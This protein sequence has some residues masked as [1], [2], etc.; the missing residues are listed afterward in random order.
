MF[1]HVVVGEQGVQEGTKY[2]PLRDPVLKIS[3]AD[4]LLPTRTT[5]GRP[6]RKS[7]IQLQGEVFRPRVLPPPVSNLSK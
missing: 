7:R 4:M 2:T 5:R 6:V 1:G 3:V